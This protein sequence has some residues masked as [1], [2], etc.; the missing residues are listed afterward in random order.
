MCAVLRLLHVRPLS[1]CPGCTAQYC[2]RSSRIHF[3]FNFEFD[4]RRRWF[5]LLPRSVV[6]T[7]IFWILILETGRTPDCTRLRIFGTVLKSENN[8]VQ[9]YDLQDRRLILFNLGTWGTEVPLSTEVEAQRARSRILTDDTRCTGGRRPPV[10]L[11][12]LI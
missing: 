2:T 9:Q 8:A 6:P 10:S 4:L 7:T 5:S 12:L 3:T 1:Q 11:N